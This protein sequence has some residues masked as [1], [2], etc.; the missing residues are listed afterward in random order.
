MHLRAYDGQA[1]KLKNEKSKFS[2]LA[3][4]M[5][6]KRRLLLTGTPIQ[7]NLHEL[8]ALLNFLRATTSNTRSAVS[9]LSASWRNVVT[10]TP[11][12]ST[13]ASRS[14]CRS[15]CAAGRRAMLR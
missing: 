5:R 8:Y 11:I 14:T 13:R 15:T 1:H 4:L 7:N 12:S 3:R 6:A 9:R 10:G 2:T